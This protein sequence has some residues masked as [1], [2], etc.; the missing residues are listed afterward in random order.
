MTLGASA[1][2]RGSAGLE[3]RVESALEPRGGFACYLARDLRLDRPVELMVLE[4]AT[5]S[6]PQ[7]AS[8]MEQARLLARVNH[9]NVAAVH[10]VGLSNGTAHIARERVDGDTLATR[11]RNGRLRPV[12]AVR[13]GRDV[14]RAL[15]AC[16]AAGVVQP[17]LT[18]STVVCL[19]DRAVL[20]GLVAA[21]DGASR[22]RDLFA[23]GRL[24]YEA[25]AGRP[26]D[27]AAGSG[28][29]AAWRAV[30]RRLRAALR[31]ALAPR[32]EERWPDAASFRR[33]LDRVSATGTR[34]SLVAGGAAGAGL[35]ALAIA[36]WASRHAIARWWDPGPPGGQSREL[37]VLP[38]E[39]AGGHPNDSLGANI[40]QLL[41]AALVNVPGLELTSQRR[42]TAW[43]DDEGG[44][45]G[46]AQ[47]AAARALEAH[48][49]V[50]GFV[51]RR[52]DS[53]WVRATLYDAEGAKAPLPE[54]HGTVHDFAGIADTLAI[55][56]L[57]AT[58]PDLEPAYRGVQ[59]LSGVPFVAIKS[60]LQGEA[61]FE[62]DAWAQAEGYYQSAIDADSDFALAHW[63]LA[64]V[65][66]WRR[67][68][69]DLDLR[70][71]Y[72]RVGSRLG[73]GDRMQ[74]EALLEPDVERRLA[75]MQAA[76][77]SAPRDA[78]TRFLYAEELFHRG[79]L[80]GRGI[81]HAARVMN[82]AIALDSSIAEAYNHLFFAAV[83]EGHRTE[84]KRL[85]ALR[86]RVSAGRSPDD[87]DVVALMGLAY[88]ERFEPWRGW[89]KRT[90]LRWGAD[91]AQVAD[92]ARAARLGAPWF[93]IPET[94]IALEGIVLA[95]GPADRLSRA[96]AHTGIGLGLLVLGR[97]GAGLAQLDSA[98]ALSP[99][100]E[101]R[102]QQA[103][104]RMV[105]QAVGL[106]AFEPAAAAAW[107]SRL[108]TFVADSATAARALWA[109]ALGRLA[110]GDTTGAERL[111]AR[112]AAAAPASPLEPLLRALLEGAR[113]RAAGALAVSDSVRPVFAVNHPPDPFAGAVFHIAR[114]GWSTAL[115]DRRA[116][117]REWR[118]YEGSDFDG[119]PSGVPQAGEIEAVFGVWAR[120]HRGAA[121]LTGATAAADTLGGC[122]LLV[123][124]TE[125]WRGA[126]ST[127][128]P[129]AAQ[130][131]TEAEACPR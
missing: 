99:T 93:D 80:V 15:E 67:L 57:R 117:D 89:L 69:Y 97:S 76:V 66:R 16:H 48:W 46:G 101:A 64:N 74:V 27:P 19:R 2:V 20:V 59:N 79:P 39:V 43:L 30:P 105:P 90:Y 9:P 118:W 60:F 81:E 87:P 125:L 23:A 41:H 86:R 25:A 94:Q 77:D 114:A 98:V 116:A 91:S 14:L 103:E 3:Y 54:L 119:W 92:L 29:G 63:R 75:R 45:I 78:Y 113:G 130:V 24:L 96:S 11:L 83:R 50:H 61:A 84:A 71:V 123:R 112:L 108:E 38:L 22:E 110:V 107:E 31:R 1:E 32:V 42:V 111:R 34:W 21:E 40:A 13:L 7:L 58:A 127:F 10:G 62:R 49:V 68:P 109:L 131:R 70:Q 47:A 17:E 120:W 35:V 37:A 122:A 115:G 88:D 26:W 72:A 104:W 56:V 95:R 106:P 52:G 55:D 12:E 124:V 36:G 82:E 4:T 44:E 121:R 51:R 73:P 126:E 85:L 102:L 18:P 33:A 128:A 6:T 65:K 100:A 53:L 5:P 28:D 8:F 129:L